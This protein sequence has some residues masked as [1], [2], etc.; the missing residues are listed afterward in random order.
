[1]ADILARLSVH[2]LSD[3][4]PTFAPLLQPLLTAS[5]I[6]NTLLVL[7]LDWS[8]PWNWIRQLRSWIH[9]LHVV[10]PALDDDARS[11]MQELMQEWEQRRRGGAASDPNHNT[12]IGSENHITVPLGPGEWDEA[13]GLPLAVVCHNV[14][15]L[16][17]LPAC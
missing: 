14:G 12:T 13:L 1:M 6:P 5:S 8:E 3:P 9:L 7:L 17:M 15:H 16:T 11:M 10:L 4:S 2:T